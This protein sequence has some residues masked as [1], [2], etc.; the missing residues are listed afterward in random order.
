[1]L[2]VA[3]FAAAMLALP[4]IAEDRAAQ[5]KAESGAEQTLSAVVRVKTRILKDARSAGT[6]GLERDGSGVLIRGGYIV[7][8]GYLV[9]EAESVEVTG[10]D[11][12]TVPASVAGYDHPSGFGLL[13]ALAPLGGRPL[14]MGDASALLEREAA[15]VASFG[16]RDGVNIVHVLRSIDRLDYFRHR[17][18][19]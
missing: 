16:G 7:T 6:L 10:A 19:Y 4:A 5:D 13:K 14:P 1:M 17:R 8:I 2:Q 18:T 12:R 3:L 9:I 15:M 11:G